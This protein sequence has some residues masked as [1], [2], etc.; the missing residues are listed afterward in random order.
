MFAATAPAAPQIRAGKLRALGTTVQTR[1]PAFP[2]VPTMI[3]SGFPGF[4][5]PRGPEAFDELIRSE[6]TRWAGVVPDAGIK[7]E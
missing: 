1:L 7:A 2:A 5:T 6:T 3:E 4:D